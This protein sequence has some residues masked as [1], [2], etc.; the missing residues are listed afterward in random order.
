MKR[1][2]SQGD[3]GTGTRATLQADWNLGVE[4]KAVCFRG[5]DIGVSQGAFYGYLK[6]GPPKKTY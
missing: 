6:G 3:M 2:E 4:S 1:K 5:P